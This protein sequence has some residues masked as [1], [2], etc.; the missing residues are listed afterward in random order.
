MRLTD[1]ITLERVRV[2]LE[3]TSKD[4]VIR[5]LLDLVPLGDD[6]IRA[7]TWR[8]IQNRE[9]LMSTGIGNGIAIPHGMVPYPIDI[10]GALGVTAEPVEFEAVDGRPVRL[11]FLLVGDENDPGKDIKALARIARLLHREE[12]RHALLTAT[13][14]EEAM[15]AI[16]QEEARHKI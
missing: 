16:E 6:K 9:M 10:V 14:P 8:A 11:V 13:S 7:A 3:G 15:G 4:A 1:L 5:A 2:P 12:F